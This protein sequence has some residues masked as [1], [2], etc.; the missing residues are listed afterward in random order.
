[1]RIVRD[2]ES[3]GVTW[4]AEDIKDTTDQHAVIGLLI[5]GKWNQTQIAS[6]IGISQGRVAQIKKEAKT[7]GYFDSR[8][9]ATEKGLEFRE[10]MDLSIYYGT[11]G[12][13]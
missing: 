4:R 3:G 11:A 13:D 5:D 7:M 12:G 8:G 10:E 6:V 9:K 2:D 1:M